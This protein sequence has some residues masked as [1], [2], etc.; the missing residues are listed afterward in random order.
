M[1]RASTAA[2]RPPPRG[3]KAVER[4][5]GSGVEMSRVAKRRAEVGIVRRRVVRVVRRERVLREDMVR[6]A[7][8]RR[9]LLIVLRWNWEIEKGLFYWSGRFRRPIEFAEDV[10]SRTIHAASSGVFVYLSKEAQA[11][12]RY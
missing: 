9:W 10:M 1:K 11:F 5:W 6:V 4:E 3:A 2:P 12:S 7:V 8:E